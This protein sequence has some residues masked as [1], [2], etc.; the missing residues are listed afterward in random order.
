M[1]NV[2]NTIY[3]KIIMKRFINNKTAKYYQNIFNTKLKISATKIKT[4]LFIRLN[5]LMKRKKF[6]FQLKFPHIRK[7]CLNCKNNKTKDEQK[8]I[9]TSYIFLPIIYF[10]I[11]QKLYFER[12]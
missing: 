4:K 6:I 9:S 3:G 1:I 7:K 5:F 2:L 8:F 10:G 12:H 11:C